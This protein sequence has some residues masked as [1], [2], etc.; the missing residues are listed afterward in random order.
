MAKLTRVT[1]ARKK[2]L[3]QPDKFV[4]VSSQLLAFGKT[5]LNQILIGIG[6]FFALIVFAAGYRYFADRTEAKASA[7]LAATVAVYEEA[8]LSKGPVDALKQ[9][10]AQFVSVVDDFAGTTAGQ[11]AR[12]KLVNAY[13]AAGEYDKAI[14]SG[15]QSL[16]ELASESPLMP[17]VISTLAY[18]FEAEGDLKQALQYFKQLAALDAGTSLK[19]DA[20]YHQGLI[21]TAMGNA[22]ESKAAFQKIADD[23][24]DFQYIGIVKEQLRS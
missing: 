23:Y 8:V 21:H 5:Y 3:E 7:M 14:V 11:T 12:L 6:V 17:F 24:P 18:A 9:A 1:L 16:E 10:E 4:T 20:W 15:K 2:E 22:A 19:A 13:S